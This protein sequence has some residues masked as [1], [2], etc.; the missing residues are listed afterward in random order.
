MG[1]TI[2]LRL[3]EEGADVV[4]NDRVAERTPPWE[5]KIR[6]L[7][8]DVVSVI[9]NVTKRADAERFVVAALERW[10]QVDLLVNSAGGFRGPGPNPS[11]EM[12]EDGR[13]G[14]TGN[15]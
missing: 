14:T 3:A 15:K 1:G 5:E 10:G 2:A 12:A 6:A 9:G 7:G 13:R 8:R 4:L 11:C